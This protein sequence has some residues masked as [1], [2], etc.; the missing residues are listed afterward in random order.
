MLY[1]RHYYFCS[2]VYFSVNVGREILRAERI[3]QLLDFLTL[4]FP[5]PQADGGI[6]SVYDEIF[7]RKAAFGGHDIFQTAFSRELLFVLLF[8]HRHNGV[9][10]EQGLLLHII[11]LLSHIVVVLLVLQ[12]NNLLPFSIVHTSTIE[13]LHF[14]LDGIRNLFL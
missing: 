8:C 14:Q 11:S 5:D 6:Y 12:I 13:I 4:L 7:W 2:I 3:V 10:V 1:N 9:V